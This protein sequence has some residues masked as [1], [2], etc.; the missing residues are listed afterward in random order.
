MRGFVLLVQALRPVHVLPERHCVTN[1]ELSGSPHVD[2]CVPAP[3]WA[4]R[5]V[6]QRADAGPQYV[7]SSR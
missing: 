5:A 2:E 7:A 6:W 4:L 1:S 3:T